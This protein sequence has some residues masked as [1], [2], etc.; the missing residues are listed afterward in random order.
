MSLIKKLIMQLGDNLGGID[1]NKVMQIIDDEEHHALYV[2]KELGIPYGELITI[3]S[4]NHDDCS[5]TLSIL[6]TEYARLQSLIADAK[7]HGVTTSM[8][9]EHKVD[10][11]LRRLR[12]AIRRIKQ[13]CRGE[14]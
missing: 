1:V 12:K 7:A 11:K 6:E 14:I 4:N 10:I 13:T 2:S 8:L 5:T 9:I 3:T